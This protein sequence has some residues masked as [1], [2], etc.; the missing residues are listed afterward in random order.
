VL[1]RAYRRLDMSSRSAALHVLLKMAA[2]DSESQ[3]KTAARA[4]KD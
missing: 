4:G 3:R 2:P 1:L